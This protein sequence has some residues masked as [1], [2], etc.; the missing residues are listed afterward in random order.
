MPGLTSFIVANGSL[1]IVL[2]L[3]VIL[4][5]RL[6]QT[7]KEYKETSY[8]KITGNSYRKVYN[9]LGHYENTEYI[10]L[11]NH[12]NQRDIDF[13]LIYIFLKTKTKQRN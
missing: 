12:M 13:Y 11:Y 10:K 6:Y 7:R 2:L 4:L 1:I 9:N 3:L 5:S 8:Y